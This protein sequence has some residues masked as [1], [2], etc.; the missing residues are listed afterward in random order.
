MEGSPAGQVVGRLD[1]TGK[2]RGC[3]PTR[4]LGSAARVACYST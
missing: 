4:Y 2:P 3:T 1:E